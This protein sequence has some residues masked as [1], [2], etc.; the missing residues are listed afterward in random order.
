MICDD[1][2]RPW[3]DRATRF[4]VHDAKGEV[5]PHEYSDRQEQRMIQALVDGRPLGAFQDL[6][7][8]DS[9]G[10]GRGW[11]IDPVRGIR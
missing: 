1:F 3:N 5:Q 6:A 4:W 7:H 11:P 8:A 9:I 2:T 10:V